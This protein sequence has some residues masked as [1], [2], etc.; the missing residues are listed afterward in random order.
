MRLAFLT[1][2]PFYPPSGGG[3]A[4]AIYLV[5]ELV[6]RGHEVEVFC[7]RVADAAGVAARFKVALREFRTWPMGRYARFRNVK[8]VLYPF[9]LERMVARAARERKF[10]LVLSQHSIAAVAA[11]K[12]R[13]RLKVPVVMNFLDYLSGF[14]ESWPSYIM[15]KPVLARIMDF[16]LSLPRRYQVDGVLTVSDTLADYFADQGYPRTRLRP[17]YYGYDAELFNTAA[18]AGLAG[19]EQPP[20]LVMHGSFDHHHLGTIAR[21]AFGRV[22]AKRPEVGLRF[23]GQR[24]AALNRLVGQIQSAHPGAKIECTG[25]LPYAEV[26]RRLAGASVGLVPYEASRGVHCAF[27]AKIV[28][29][30]AMGLPVVSTPLDSPMRYFANEP[31]A[32][33]SGFDGASFA[34][35]ILGWLDEPVARRQALAPPAMEKVKA[36]LDWRVISRNAVDFVE[37]TQRAAASPR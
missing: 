17:I 16:E 12:L 36:R 28:E 4:E 31:L 25:F 37:A 24:T 20:V 18:R 2:E 13:A 33:F 14:M 29:Y 22:L 23:V 3:S 34:E 1:H 9:F 7:P 21:E 8:Y 27:V 5:E 26:A 15:P 30:I 19:P 35:K 32:R 11:G 6:R 10:D